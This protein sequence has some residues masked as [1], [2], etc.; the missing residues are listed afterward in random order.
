MQLSKNLEDVKSSC[1][2]Q[3]VQSN[4][5]NGQRNFQTIGE[6]ESGASGEVD[7]IDSDDPFSCS[8]R[9]FI[10]EVFGVKAKP[11]KQSIEMSYSQYLNRS[12]NYCAMD[13]GESVASYVWES[14]HWGRFTD[15]TGKRMALN[16]LQANE[17]QKA[18]HTT[19][20][21]LHN[22]SVLAMPLL[23][24]EPTH[25]VVPM[26]NVWLTVSEDGQFTIKR[27][28]KTWGVKYVIDADLPLDG[29]REKMP[30]QPKPLP[31]ESLF[32]QFL[33]VSLPDE[34]VR[35]LVQEYC[36]YTLLNDVRHQVAQIWVGDGRNGKSVLLKIIQKLHAKVGSLQLDKLDGFG[37]TSLVDS[38]LIVCSEAPKRGINEQVFKQIISGDPISVEYKFKDS[39][40]YSPR[41]KF[42]I[43]CNRFPHITDDSN[44]VWRRLQIIKWDVNLTDE[45]EIPNIDEMI[46][47]K[48]LQLVVDWCLEGLSRLLV[49]GD[50]AEP[51]SVLHRKKAE[52]VNSN[53]VLAFVEDHGLD[54]DPIGRSTYKHLIYERYEEYCHSHGLSPFQGNEFWKRVLQKF[55]EM[56]EK[57]KPDSKGARL[58]AVNL[59]LGNH[60]VN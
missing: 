24:P 10:D 12:G 11:K 3:P 28:D 38:S 20:C 1:E 58:R 9:D 27:A 60:P 32:H 54:V 59:T 18:S 39:F 45:Q 53:N 43:A 48:E 34:D 2:I 57:K 16:W 31:E 23:P 22:T 19:A 40:T 13:N 6:K 46:I 36:G 8:P 52:K 50:F 41:G 55:P 33:S 29:K 15:T 56:K 17:P 37:L 14:S 7:Q 21:S 5:L 49:R 51:E 26:R 25:T 44:G 4:I 42:L 35:A 30:Y 47:S